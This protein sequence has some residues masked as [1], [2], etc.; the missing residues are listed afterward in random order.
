MFRGGAFTQRM[1]NFVVYALLSLA[2]TIIHFQSLIVSGFFC[3]LG[4][5]I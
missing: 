5:S 2:K 3:L 4:S 1:K